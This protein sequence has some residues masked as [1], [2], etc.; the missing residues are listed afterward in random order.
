ME[1]AIIILK[2]EMFH[3]FSISQFVCLEANDLCK[4]HMYELLK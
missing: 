2:N 4:Q 3:T 1:N